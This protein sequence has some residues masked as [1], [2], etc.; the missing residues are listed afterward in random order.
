MVKLEIE[1]FYHTFDFVLHCAKNGIVLNRDKFQFCQD[2]VQFGGP[3][4]TPSGV[5][6]FRV[7]VG[8]DIKLPSSKDNH[9]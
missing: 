8:G 7:Y 1:A 6:S 3:Q 5:T 9:R 2:V 4:I